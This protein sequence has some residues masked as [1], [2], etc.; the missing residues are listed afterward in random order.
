[1]GT[2]ITKEESETDIANGSTPYITPKD[3]AKIPAISI[4]EN[5]AKQKA[6]ALIS[7]LGI[8]YLK[9]Y[10]A[11]KLYGGSDE[12]TPDLGAYINPRQ[13]VWYLRYERNVNGIPTTYTP[14]ECMKVDQE[15]QSAPWNYEDMTFAIDDSGIVG[16]SWSSPYKVTGTVTENSNL[17][18]FQKSMA[19]FDSMAPVVH[20]WEGYGQDNPRLLGVEMNV[21]HIQLGLSRITEQDK[22]DSGLLVPVWDFLEV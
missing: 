17:L 2:F 10:T 14:Y 7:A 19:V 4:T 16:F 12:Q 9:C 21:N 6:E 5:G 8:N 15:N 18:S 20:A 1:M 3:I 22:R 11:Q 13:S